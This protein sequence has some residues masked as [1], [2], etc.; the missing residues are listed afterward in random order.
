MNL[1][2]KKIQNYL[3]KKKFDFFIFTNSDIH[4]NEN[5][6]LFLK[7]IFVLTGF[8]CSYGYLLVMVDKCTFFTDSRYTLAAGK[9]FT[10]KTEIFDVKDNSIS[11]YLNSLGSNLRG[12]IDP[13]LISLN[14]FQ[15][16]EKNL[17]KKNSK[18][19]TIKKK[20]IVK[21]YY[22]NFDNAYA[23]SLPKYY[24][25]RPFKKNINWVKNNLKTQGL[26]IW[27]N[28]HIA[29]LLNIRSFELNNSTKPFAGLFIS[30]KMNK[31]ILISKNKYLDNIKKIKDNFYILS[32]KNFINLLKK[33][34]IDSLELDYNYTNLE[35][36][37]SLSKFCEVFKTKIDIDKFLSK[38]TNV[39]FKN[40]INCH[41]EDGIALTKFIIKTKTHLNLFRNEYSFV[42]ELYNFRKQGINYFRN[43]F[44]YISALGKNAA[45]VHYKPLSTKSEK[46]TNQSL[47]LLDSGA[48]YLE[49]TTDV[50][51]VLK[52][53]GSINKNIKNY[54]TYLLKSLLKIESSTFKKGIS[55]YDLDSFVRNYLSKYNIFYGHGTGHGVG[56]FNDVHEKYPIIS[57]NFKKNLLNNNL[58]SIEPGFYSP[59][60]FGLRIENLYFAKIKKNKLELYNVTLVPYDLDLVNMDLLSNKEKNS[61]KQ[62][63]KK[64][65][66]F[67]ETNF[68]NFE[69]KYFI[70][71][72]I[73]KI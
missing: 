29:Y 67:F 60:Y 5:P 6:N 23:F 62:Y 55:G 72:L 43:S 63:H 61:I 13:R 20:I 52:L 34:K 59:N 32:E 30:K 73:N 3:K 15:I 22:P 39:E 40:I 37:I 12:L 7:D 68:N 27:N 53:K 24:I 11:Q 10:K 45:I 28:A 8:D 31:S 54:Y 44:D 16:L 71:K 2:I 69:K 18:I 47:L 58:F 1:K 70:D 64:I 56:Y 9:F 35:I 26:L 4:L 57:K 48:H 42:K 33:E 36:F 66:S 50:T 65:F 21:N 51:R 17:S 49:G 41:K 46:F 38:K 19:L 14:D 25:P